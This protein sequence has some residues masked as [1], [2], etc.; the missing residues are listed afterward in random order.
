[1]HIGEL[2]IQPNSRYSLANLSSKKT[3]Q[4]SA[5]STNLNP[6]VMKFGGT[7]VAHP[8]TIEVMHHYVTQQKQES[9]VFVLSALAGTTDLLVEI[10]QALHHNNVEWTLN[11][12]KNLEAIHLNLLKAQD[13]P[14]VGIG[15]QAVWQIFEQRIQTQL[16]CLPHAPTPGQ[17]DEILAFGERFSTE[18]YTRLLLAQGIDVCPIPAEEW[19]VTNDQFGHA[20]PLL[21]E[22]Q[23][24]I[25]QHLQP[26]L[27]PGRV[28]LTQG[29]TG[30]TT[31]GE[32]TTLG[33]GGSDLSATFLAAQLKAQRAVIWTDSPGILSADPRQISS[34]RP[35]PFLTYEQAE[36]LACN[37]AKILHFRA[38][39]P[40]KSTGIPL[41]I[42]SAF[43]PNGP[44]SLVGST[45]PKTESAF[46]VSSKPVIHP[47]LLGEEA[48]PS[49]HLVDM[50]LVPC[51]SLGNSNDLLQTKQHLEAEALTYRQWVAHLPETPK[52]RTH[53]KFTSVCLFCKDLKEHSDLVKNTQDLLMRNSISPYFLTQA[54]DFDC[55][56]LV[57]ATDQAKVALELVHEYLANIMSRSPIV[58]NETSPNNGEEEQLISN[59]S[60][61]LQPAI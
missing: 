12:K 27:K 60:Y 58:G 15:F 30:T 5:T 40:L 2:M 17:I 52:E 44:I 54:P 32:L 42:R 19:L 29:F 31:R 50:P 43:L 34:A 57:V 4:C 8:Q 45:S 49:R 22:S 10:C 23:E 56:L 36:T 61:P 33:R 53:P 38:L 39:K 18:I 47:S 37:G 1:M 55:A 51:S 9:W 28:V 41:E 46:S 25:K 16:D 20:H 7:S 14:E 13:L 48:Y 6:E 21:E 26:F 11:A 35:L 3:S 24:K 59:K